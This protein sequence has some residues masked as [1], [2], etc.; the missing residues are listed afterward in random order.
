MTN[1]KDRWPHLA[2]EDRWEDPRQRTRVVPMEVLALGF[3]RTGTS[4]MHTALQ[5]LGITPVCHGEDIIFQTLDLEMIAQGIVAKYQPSAATCPPFGRK[6]FDQLLG[7]YRAVTDMP[8]SHFGPELMEAYPDAKVVLVERDIES[9]FKS[10]SET[11]ALIPFQCG[12]ANWLI[13]SLDP[14]TRRRRQLGDTLFRLVY[15]ADSRA[16][17]L[18]TMRDVYREHYAAIRQAARPGQLLEYKLGSGWE[19]LCEFLGK[20]V[21]DVPFP[22]INDSA[23]FAEK[24]RLVRE[25]LAVGVR[26][27]IRRLL[28]VF[29][30]IAA[31]ALAVGWRRLS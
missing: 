25:H 3:S 5:I 24:I 9:W 10:Y 21:P 17:I 14:L 27:R 22:R 28:G 29:G 6:E 1:L 26:R 2:E 8:M 15:R 7:Q 16:E 4:S 12:F 31:V 13:N 18:E 19:P 11:V 23:E 30:V 20:P